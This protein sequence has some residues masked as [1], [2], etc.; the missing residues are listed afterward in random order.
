MLL[1]IMA[2]NGLLLTWIS[3]VFLLFLCAV[4][5][6]AKDHYSKYN[7]EGLVSSKNYEV[8]IN[9]EKRSPNGTEAG[10]NTD[11]NDATVPTS[12]SIVSTSTPS[13]TSNPD[14]PEE[15]N[16]FEDADVIHD[17]HR[18]YNSVYKWL[19]DGLKDHWIELDSPVTHQTLSKGHRV[20]AVI[21]LKFNFSFY[22][23]E[24]TKVTV[25]TGGFIY[26]SPFLHQW[27]TAT[28]YIA[29]LMANF[30]PSISVNSTIMYQSEADHMIIEWKDMF[31]QDQKTDGGFHFQVTLFA[32]N[33]IKFA[34]LKVPE[35][36]NKI[37]S[38]RHPVKIGLSDAYYNDTY[39]AE[40][41]IKRRTIYEYHKVVLNVTRIVSNSIVYIH[42]LPTCNTLKSCETCSK[43]TGVDF[44]CKWCNRIGRCS[45][46]FDW[47]R[48]H[49]DK[50]GCKNKHTV[51]SSACSS[52]PKPK[53]PILDPHDSSMYS[54]LKCKGGDCG[55]SKTSATTVAVILVIAFIIILVGGIGAW[56]Y[57]A[58]THPTSKSG[59]W[60]MEHRPS[61]LGAKIRFW[62]SS[63]TSGSKY[64]TETT[65]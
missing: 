65:A 21:P 34:Y 51:D 42:P 14:N 48:Q 15:N 55:G 10:N 35:S 27:L 53:H 64:Q 37:S 25:A 13:T 18:Y 26:M 19:K 56:V 30:D 20:A 49:W 44:E 62:K 6:S 52:L 57:Y 38:K 43:H 39:M 54:R 58:Y 5:C 11:D 2:T 22:G 40:F 36:V 23:H 46:G 59:M 50:Q 4:R 60:L 3:F 17:N 9:R 63:N 24:L 8:H 12:V 41:D 29:P 31:L 28:Q 45:D 33:T 47:Y 7:I 61:Q 32:N 16:P 1:G